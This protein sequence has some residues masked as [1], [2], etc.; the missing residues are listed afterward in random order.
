MPYNEAGE[1]RPHKKQIEFLSVPFSIK[2]AA[3]LGGAGSAK[4]ET[5]L[6]YGIAH[7]LHEN[8]SFKQVFLRRTYPELKLEVVPRSKILYRPFGARFNASDM[9]WTFPSGGIIKLGHCEHE[10]DVH[11][12]DS[13][14]ISLFTPDEVTHLTEWIYLYIGLQRTRAPLGSSLPAIIRAAGM[15]GGV[16]HTWVKKRFVDPDKRGGKIIVGRGGVKRIFIFATQADNPHIDPNYKQS[17]EA[18]PEAEKQAKLYGSF[19][20]YL[21]QVFNEFRDKQY[22]DEP[23]NALHVVERFEIPDW[24]PKIAAGDW[25]FAAMTWIGYG[26]ISPDQR[27][28]IY[29]EQSWR[30]TKIEEWAPY[31]RDYIEKE[32]PRI[33]KFCKSAGQDR[34]QE[35]T[36]QQQIEDA[37]G[38]PIDLVTNNPGSRVA[39]KQLLHEY[40]RWKPKRS[41]IYTPAEYSQEH[42]EWLIRNRSLKEYN[43]YLDSFKAPEEETNLPKLLI[44]NTCP[45]LIN[46]IK[47]CVYAKA[48]EG[49]VAEDVAEFDGDDPY[50]G[51][52]YLVDTADRYFIES[53]EEF[54]RV[55]AR[56]E[57]LKK[58]NNTNDWTAFYRNMKRVES[59]GLAKPI[60]RYRH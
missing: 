6:M 39:T 49:Q 9:V 30:N 16:G 60:P 58:L 11:Q 35:H 59:T 24:W 17:L 26:A 52:R 19:D 51:I 50:D 29:R 48:R 14:E 23:K 42:A 41:P 18:L 47:S 21:G 44:F 12:Y 20:A 34:G 2:E 38:R 45:I 32:N 4:T 28:I 40:L 5:L 13:M 55:Q 56:D 43:S 46:A 25:G 15:P 22:P 1:W 8:P 10:D 53:A 54:K 7:K 27:V 36:I 33:I 3:Y 37:I 57:L 31:F